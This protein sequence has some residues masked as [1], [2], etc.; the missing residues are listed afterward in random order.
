MRN[1][2]V[3][4][5]NAILKGDKLNDKIKAGLLAWTVGES[6]MMF[7]PGLRPLAG[8]VSRDTYNCLKGYMNTTYS[9]TR[10]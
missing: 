2:Q 1:A 3:T 10:S 4:E 8:T 5:A 6:K 7:K 9:L